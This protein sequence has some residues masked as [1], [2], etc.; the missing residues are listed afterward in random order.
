[1]NEE[2]EFE[3]FGFS[4]DEILGKETRLGNARHIK[5]LPIF[6]RQ[7]VILPYEKMTLEVADRA[8]QQMIDDVNE[9]ESLIGISYQP[10]GDKSIPAPGTLGVAAQIQGITRTNPGNL[11]L[12][13]I[14]GMVRYKT[15]QYVETGKPYPV[16]TI[17]YFDDNDDKR[18]RKMLPQLVAEFKSLM[19]RYTREWCDNNPRMLRTVDSFETR[20]AQIY[21]W[22]FWDLLPAPPEGRPALLEI[23]STATRLYAFNQQFKQKLDWVKG[24][25]RL[26]NN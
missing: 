3:D 9:A 8:T 21:S 18:H 19:K 14:E 26:S 13:E 5:Q 10:K 20:G 24:K 6:P 15:A 7:V 25:P 22:L 11:Y 1:M 17:N 4:L 16:A 23:R 12:V 2:N